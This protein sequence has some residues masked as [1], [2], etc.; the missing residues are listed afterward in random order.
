MEYRELSLVNT[1]ASQ[2]G[3]IYQTISG[4][5]LASCFPV[6][7]GVVVTCY[8]ALR[9]DEYG[10]DIGYN[11]V[12]P[13]LSFKCHA[14]IIRDETSIENDVVFL[15]LDT[16]LS[17]NVKLLPLGFRYTY[18]GYFSSFGYRKVEYYY[19]LFASGKLR[20]EIQA[21]DGR[22][23]LQLHSN[24]IDR[25]MSGAPILDLSYETIVGMISEYWSASSSIDCTL[26]F[27]VPMSRLIS[28]RPSISKIVPELTAAPKHL[29]S[30]LFNN[31]FNPASVKFTISEEKLIRACTRAALLVCADQFEDG[32]WGRSLWKET[33]RIRITTDAID[34]KHAA[35]THEKKAISVTAWAAQALARAATIAAGEFR[36][37]EVK[38]SAH[39][40]MM[41]QEKETGAFGNI[42]ESNSATPLV[43]RSSLIRSPRHTASGIKLIELAQGLNREVVKGCEFIVTNECISEGGW[44]EA[45]GDPPN[46]LATAYV[47]DSLIKLLQVPGL[48]SLLS[49]FVA[50]SIRP[51][52]SRGMAWLIGQRDD[53]YLWQYSGNQEYKP[54]YSAFILG[55]V[56]QLVDGFYEET[57]ESLEALLK[58]SVGG[59]I[60]SSQNGKPD[61]LATSL[62]LYAMLRIDPANHEEWIQSS[63]TWLVN[64]WI[65]DDWIYDYRC[66]H[67]IFSL[68]ALTQLPN[69]PRKKL[70]CDLEKIFVNTHSRCFVS[71]GDPTFW[72]SVDKQLDLGLS[73]VINGMYS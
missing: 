19:G 73:D 34:K 71:Q 49:P 52:I 39:F 70:S 47:L 20:E 7:P 16:P 51:A 24:E 65:S 21:S 68:V 72:L 29:E 23:L 10:S 55:F 67:G 46:V 6:E 69:L 61:S 44:G 33:G 14:T 63:I 37:P 38:K 9:V 18:N 53:D 8:H 59:G 2:V 62:C 22:Q 45:I 36:S 5:L 11:L 3:C 64:N 32:S 12:F 13:R 17:Q 66:M 58:L 4:E 57:V 15:L 54:L 31:L 35:L 27:A 60:P 26:A 42:Y 48:R 28:V 41:Y 50:K 30:G 40:A 25:G 1:L 43:S 56:P